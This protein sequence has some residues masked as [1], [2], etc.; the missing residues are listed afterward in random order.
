MTLRI[1]R[2]GAAWA[3]LVALGAATGAVAGPAADKAAEAE[4]LLAAGDTVEAI[5]AFDEATAAFWAAMPLHL[6]KAIFVDSVTAYGKY[7]PH[8]GVVFRSGDLVTVYL[9]P[10]GYDLVDAAGWYRAAFSTALQI[11]TADGV[12]L[13]DS[14]DFAKLVWAGQAPSHEV[15]LTIS[16][17]MPQL[18]PGDYELVLRLTEDA[19]GDITTTTLSFTI[20]G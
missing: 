12:I 17:A 5:A 4:A 1:S 2:L 6:R 11:R 16:V 14:E 10:V 3:A 7:E 9:E 15:P 19:T 18:K 13:A 8:A 20:A